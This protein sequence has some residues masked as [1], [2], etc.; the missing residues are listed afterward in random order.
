M[1]ES[2]NWLGDILFGGWLRD[3]PYFIE[4]VSDDGAVKRNYIIYTV[5][6]YYN[7]A[8]HK[9]VKKCSKFISF[10]RVRDIRAFLRSNNQPIYMNGRNFYEYMFNKYHR[11]KESILALPITEY[12]IYKDD[13]YH[14]IFYLI[15]GRLKGLDRE[16]IF[17]REGECTPIGS[18]IA[19]SLV[20]VAATRIFNDPEQA[21]VELIVN[22]LDSYGVRQGL[23]K[24]GRFGMGFFSIMYFLVG[25]PE[26]HILIHTIVDGGK[27]G[28]HILSSLR[29]QEIDGTL[30]F[31]VNII[32]IQPATPGTIFTLNDPSGTLNAQKSVTYI[33][34]L[35]LV[36]TAV[37]RMANRSSSNSI[38]NVQGLFGISP[39]EATDDRE[40]YTDL[41]NREITDWIDVTNTQTLFSVED[42][43]TGIRPETIFGSLLIPSISTKGMKVSEF[44]AYYENYSAAYPAKNNT[45]TFSIAINHIKLFVI[46]FESIYTNIYDIVLSLPSDVVLPV[47][48]DDIII[49]KDI[50]KEIEKSVFKLTDFFITKANIHSLCLAIDAYITYTS[51]VNNKAFMERIKNSIYSYTTSKGYVLVRLNDYY[52]LSLV[53]GKC[54]VSD[55]VDF[56]RIE[57]ILDEA[58]LIYHEDIFIS[59]RVVLLS[60]GYDGKPTSAGT[61]KYLFVDDNTQSIPDWKSSL[62]VTFLEEKLYS[63]DPE[64]KQSDISTIDDFMG[65][66]PHWYTGDTTRIR[67]YYTRVLSL[68]TKLELP[69]NILTMAQES[70]LVILWLIPDI[71]NNYIDLSISVYNKLKPNSEYGSGLKKIG[72][73]PAIRYMWTHY[74]QE[75][76]HTDQLRSYFRS[77]VE[78]TM[79]C[80]YFF[81]E[82]ASIALIFPFTDKTMKFPTKPEL[83]DLS[84][85]F[86]ELMF[87]NHAYLQIGEE[88]V[89]QMSSNLHKKHAAAA[90]II[91]NKYLKKIEGP[92]LLL[93]YFVQPM[94]QIYATNEL[95]DY[96]KSTMS[97]ETQKIE[98]IKIDFNGPAQFTNK[99]LISYIFKSNTLNF[100][101][102]IPAIS[103]ERPQEDLQIIEIAVDA[104]T[105]KSFIEATLTELIQNSMDAIRITDANNKSISITTGTIEDFDN[106]CFCSIQD[107]VGMDMSNLQAISIPFYSN[108]TASEI[109]TGEMGTGFFNVYRESVVVIIDTVK[110]GHRIIIQDRPVRKNGRIQDI[111]KRVTE[112]KTSSPNGTKI[113]FVVRQESQEEVMSFLSVVSYLVHSVFSYMNFS[114]IIFNGESA[115]RSK[116]LI[117]R[118][119]ELECYKTDQGT[120]SYIFTKGV[121]FSVLFDYLQPIISD[122][123]ISPQQLEFMDTNVI[124]NIRHGFYTPVQSR[125]KLNISPNNLIKLQKFLK[126]SLFYAL[127]EYLYSACVYYDNISNNKKELER[128]TIL[129]D[130]VIEDRKIA[131]TA[132]NTLPPDSVT[133]EQR[134]NYQRIWRQSVDIRK[135]RDAILE[136]TKPASRVYPL[137]ENMGGL[138]LFNKVKISQVIPKSLSPD[139]QIGPRLSDILFYTRPTFA[140]PMIEHLQEFC[141]SI[142]MK[143]P[144]RYPEWRIEYRKYADSIIKR[145]SDIDA[146]ISSEKFFRIME[147]WIATKSPPGDEKAD[148]TVL[149]GYDESKIVNLVEPATVI[150]QAYVNAFLLL[151]SEYGLDEYPKNLPVKFQLQPPGSLAYFSK[152]EIVVNTYHVDP[153]QLATFMTNIPEY[154]RSISLLRDDPLYRTYFGISYPASII[155]HELE[156]ARRHQKHDQGGVHD[157]IEVAIL[158]KEKKRYTYDEISNELLLYLSSKGLVER[159]IQSL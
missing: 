76:T 58:K 134:E 120:K 96:I 107:Y 40:Y 99:Q 117:Y 94:S 93:V 17:K 108:K 4:K 8:S 101:T 141:S 118:L 110:D 13:N 35:T 29:I 137:V 143:N 56:Q 92:R 47:T 23:N 61:Y 111:D 2:I 49:D 3:V 27:D 123:G 9:I 152:N 116:S 104:G 122:L 133:P 74:V 44:K 45:A 36:N 22:S 90:K 16:Q 79:K 140:M 89:F 78:E 73:T 12:Y 126:E 11:T 65:R 5:D 46:N 149:S 67:L 10:T 156:H 150:F 159:F 146:K 125:T 87:L 144:E 41:A 72:G 153:V 98:T 100:A 124:I 51:N 130:R 136:Q 85:T 62:L 106:Y 48:R 43:G 138:N 91:Y 70:L 7:F 25:H 142:W 154:K 69:P 57:T 71:L 77:Y 139:Q 127:L 34:Y 115:K 28:S 113:T 135:Q 88:N 80:C 53:I 151:A 95:Y 131:L 60:A 157:D 114:D 55:K 83:L 50:E 31:K 103:R 75:K 102:D 19:S 147:T 97:D 148:I 39:L 64:L 52:I 26:R 33:N 37:I 32:Q 18:K 132:I 121:P 59:K 24:T 66:L 15:C 86:Y 42:R 112:L 105:S 119:D 145:V 14:D 68:Y 128:L 38:W 1:D 63:V 158:G 82:W 84:L 81:N 30:R 20:K 21:I 6:P 54:I 129:L 109:A 155:P